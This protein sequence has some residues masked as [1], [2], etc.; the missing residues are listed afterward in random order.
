MTF[1]NSSY[2]YQFID[3]SHHSITFCMNDEKT[4][5]SINNKMFRRLGYI[6]DLLYKVELANSAIEHKEPIIVGFF[7]LQYAKLRTL[8]L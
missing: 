6:H 7:F 4:R 3:C 5:A 1:A 8:E 2:G